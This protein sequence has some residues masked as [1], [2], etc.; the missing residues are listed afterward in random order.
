MIE[1]VVEERIAVLRVAVPVVMVAGRERI[2][3]MP[4]QNRHARLHALPCRD[5]GGHLNKITFVQDESNLLGLCVCDDP[6][7]DLR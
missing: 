2:G 5:V 7:G 6:L 3:D 1:I 4:V